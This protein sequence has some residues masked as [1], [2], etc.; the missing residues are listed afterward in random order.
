[1]GRRIEGQGN[2]QEKEQVQDEQ[3]V[4]ES[5]GT[6]GDEGV[7]AGA[8]DEGGEPEY[9]P[10]YGYNIL[11]ERHEM[12]ERVRPYIKSKEDEQYYRDLFERAHGLD[13]VKSERQR[14]REEKEQVSEKLNQYE[15]AVQYLQRLEQFKQNGDW[16]SYF[17]AQGIPQNVILQHAK[18][19]LDVA[20]DPEKYQAY[21]ENRNQFWQA[22]TYEQQVQQQ[23]QMLH[24]QRNREVDMVIQLDPQVSDAARQFDGPRIC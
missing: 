20:Q 1:M 11:D 17:E 15:P 5:V 23:Q 16:T 22:Q 3:V 8:A 14:L 6:G 4:D 19:V 2:D 12:P 10:D 21:Q 7:E 18:Q 13:H 24:E 9:T